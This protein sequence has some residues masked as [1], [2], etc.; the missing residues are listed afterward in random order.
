MKIKKI[1]PTKEIIQNYNNQ[2]NIRRRVVQGTGYEFIA[3][4]TDADS[5]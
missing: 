4:A 2:T 1:E 5:D 3:T